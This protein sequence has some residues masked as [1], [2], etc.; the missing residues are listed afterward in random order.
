MTQ[1]DLVCRLE[2]FPLAGVFVWRPKEA[3]T[4]AGRSWNTRFAWRVAGSMDTRGHIQVCID[5]RMYAA[6]RLA[7]LYVYG[8]WPSSDLDHKDQIKTNNR[9]AN[10]R[11]A[12]RS[13]NNV[14]RSPR[15][16]NTSGVVGVSW[17]KR[18]GKWAAYVGSTHLGYFDSRE[19][20]S[21]ARTVAARS[22][23]GEFAESQ[24][25]LVPRE[26]AA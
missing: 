18:V 20:A 13:E 12:T 4:R 7:W 6:H 25:D 15:R 1:A 5:G 8:S 16:D 3:T 14:N 10:L 22:R 26:D 2:Y 24:V 21:A 9:I 17:H 11:L 19:A 23:F